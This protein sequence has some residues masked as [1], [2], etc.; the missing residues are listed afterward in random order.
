MVIAQTPSGGYHAVY[1]CEVEVCGNLKLAQRKT[2]KVQTLIETRGEG[3]LFLCAPTDGYEFIHNDFSVLSVISGD[4][5]DKLLEAAWALN[6][7]VPEP[8][9]IID[10][11]PVRQSSD[12][13]RPGART[14]FLRRL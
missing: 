1:R 5:R 2:D 14:V 6:E 9:D 13:L 8:V 11:G 4:E 3:G 10:K 12:G 7:Y